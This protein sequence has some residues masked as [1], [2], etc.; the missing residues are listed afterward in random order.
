VV[1]AKNDPAARALHAAALRY[2]AEYLQ[3]DWWDRAEGPLPNPEVRY[4]RL[5]VAAAFICTANTCSNPV[6]DAD[7]IVAGAPSSL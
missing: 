1:G 6:Y 2:P 5:A 7:K 3:V 4:P